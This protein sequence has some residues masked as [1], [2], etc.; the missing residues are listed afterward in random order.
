MKTTKKQSTLVNIP[1]F[2]L[3]PPTEREKHDYAINIVNVMYSM[4]IAVYAF[5]DLYDYL[6]D[7][8]LITDK[9]QLT[10]NSIEERIAKIS[11]ITFDPIK[12]AKRSTLDKYSATSCELY[13]KIKESIS[14][15]DVDTLVNIVLQTLRTAGYFNRKITAKSR[16][17][18][19]NIS[20]IVEANMKKV[21]KYNRIDTIETTIQ[22]VIA[23]RN[24]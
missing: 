11:N 19:Y 9:N 17:S 21:V 5:D 6:K 12:T 2:K 3:V 14:D 16:T 20:T 13:N 18:L 22:N 15:N 4:Q 7:N 1:S 24:K 8:D 23:N 10:L